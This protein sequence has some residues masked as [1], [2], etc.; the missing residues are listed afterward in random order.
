M[1][2]RFSYAPFVIPFTVGLI[3]IISYFAFSFI[4]LLHDLSWADRK[5][6]FR[7]I[8]SYKIFVSGWEAVRE[9]LLHVK[10]FRRNKLLGFMHMSIAFGWF[11]MI[12]LAHVEVKIYAPHRFNLPYYPIFSGTYQGDRLDPRRF[13]PVFPDGLFSC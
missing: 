9:C 12:L 11:M 13:V 4:K 2:E 1:Q 7:S 3:Y 5:R 10:M 6:F 8:F